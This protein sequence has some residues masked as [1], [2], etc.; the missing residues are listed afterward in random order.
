[1]AEDQNT[2]DRWELPS[3]SEPV[4][5]VDR[6]E[7]PSASEP[8]KN[9]VLVGRTGNGKSATG[10]SIIGRK[11][12]ESKY[13]AVGVTTRCKT[14]RA[15]TPDGPIIN[16]IDTPGMRPLETS[17]GIYCLLDHMSLVIIPTQIINTTL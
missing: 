2:T 15:V 7:L 16:V 11:V 6:W 12:F 14:F 10:N 17:N 1:M 8:V 9:V 13:Q 3:A 5:N 4:K